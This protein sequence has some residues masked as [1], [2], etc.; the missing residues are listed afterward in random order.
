[1]SDHVRGYRLTLRHLAECERGWRAWINP[2]HPEPALYGPGGA[3]F[4]HAEPDQ[5]LV[6]AAFADLLRERIDGR[7]GQ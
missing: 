5:A 6:E 4:D 2:D 7:V 1:M 3:A